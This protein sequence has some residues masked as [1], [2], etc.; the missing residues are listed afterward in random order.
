[1]RDETLAI[2]FGY[3]PDS[4]RAVAVPIYQTVAHDFLDASH[5]AAIFDMEIPGFHYNRINNPTNDVLEKRLCA[6]EQGKA[7]LVTATGAA[8]V[9]I[10]LTTLAS[11]GC[12]FVCL[13]HL[14]GATYTYLANVLC[15][16]GVETRFV[17]D[18][19]PEGISKLIDAKTRALFCESIGNPAGDLADLELLAS[20]AHEEGIPLV[21]DNTIATP[22]RLKPIRHGADVVIHS[23][24]KFVGGH[25]VAM[26]GAIIDA[27]SFDWSRDPDR[28][29]MFNQP[30]PA[31]HQTV[32]AERFPDFAF[33]A[34]ARAVGLRNTGAALS[35]FNA[36]LL[37][38]GLETLDVRLERQE[39]NAR[40]IANYLSSHPK[41]SWLEFSGAPDNPQRALWDR[42]M[43]GRCVS[44]I[45]FGVEG[46]E[47]AAIRFF[48]SLRL[49]KRL[50]NMGDTKSLVIHPASTTHRQLSPKEKELAGVRPDMVRLSIGLEHPEDLIEDLDQALEQATKRPVGHAS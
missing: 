11:S 24:T 44:I 25:G 39:R 36:F 8:A 7:A 48:D 43:P 2:H 32:F 50:V 14:Y 22:L 10:T 28:F 45:T 33:V 15:D 47:E 5:A 30:D 13:P 16:Y 42:Y 27:G 20:V 31:Y 40:A 17:K 4:T 26:G 23:L 38:E 49:F 12:N 41:V 34:R 1:M 3:E 21:V 35:P 6:L 46:G 37:L 18:P 19:S 9:S 29:P